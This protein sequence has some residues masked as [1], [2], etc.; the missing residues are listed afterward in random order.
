MENN[1]RGF[2]ELAPP[3]ISDEVASLPINDE[4]VALLENLDFIDIQEILI[5][6]EPVR[7]V[8]F[9]G[10]ARLFRLMNALRE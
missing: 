7:Q 3:P 10:Q 6:N 5:Y 9:A 2:A 8:L 1:V 4:V